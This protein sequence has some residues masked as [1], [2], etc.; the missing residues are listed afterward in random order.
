RSQGIMLGYESDAFRWDAAFS[1]G[2]VFSEGVNGELANTGWQMRDT[3]YAIT[4]RIDFL[5]SGD[6]WS[7]FK[8]FTSWNDDPFAA[9]IGAAVH[10]QDG[11]YGD[12]FDEEAEVLQWTIDGAIEG[13]GWNLFAAFNGAD[14]DLNPDGANDPEQW[15]FMVQGGVFLVPDKFEL[16]GRWEWLDLDASE[17]LLDDDFDTND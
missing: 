3:E 9:K 16:F 17:D 11:E 5:V 2:Y 13:G 1:D 4:S 15:G 7:Q 6:S 8:D 14:V 10:W 12:T